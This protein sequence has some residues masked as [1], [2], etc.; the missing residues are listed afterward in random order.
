MAM[1]PKTQSRMLA[2]LSRYHAVQAEHELAWHEFDRDYGPPIRWLCVHRLDLSESDVDDVLQQV[3]MKVRDKVDS[4][5]GKS[6]GKCRFRTWL[7][8]LTANTVVDHLRKQGLD[9]KRIDKLAEELTSRPNW[10][11]SAIELDERLDRP[12]FLDRANDIL[13]RHGTRLKSPNTLLA[14]CLHVIGGFSL[15]ETAQALGISKQGV[16]MAVSRVERLLDC[17]SN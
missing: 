17:H 12:F 7:R 15:D 10:V 1:F 4:F 3:S 8:M 9:E 2:W 13:A 14:F 5:T 11:D 16:S 6:S